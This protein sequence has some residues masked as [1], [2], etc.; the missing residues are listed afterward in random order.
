MYLTAA[1]ITQIDAIT[2]MS[3]RAFATDVEVGGREG[4]CPPEYDSEKWHRQ[5]AEEGHL[6]AAMVNDAL[7]GAAILFTDEKKQ[8]MYIGRIFIDSIYHKKGYGKQLMACIENEFPDI[9]EFNLDTPSWNVRTNAF[10]TKLGYQKIKTEDG[11][12]YYQK[13]K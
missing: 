6:L 7:V 1:D 5:M 8:S 12:V 4:D 2:A 13:R 3:I 11:F 10:Y 9:R